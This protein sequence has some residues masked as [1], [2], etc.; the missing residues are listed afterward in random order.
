MVRE[1]PFSSRFSADSFVVVTDLNQKGGKFVGFEPFLC[2]PLRPLI[3]TRTLP[4]PSRGPLRSFNGSV[5]SIVSRESI[6]IP[7][8]SIHP[9]PP[10][11][12]P[13]ILIV[14]R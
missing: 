1:P 7:S 8:V 9:P 4:V 13:T 2:S 14:I 11:F 5:G 12:H 10:R 3:R 6:C